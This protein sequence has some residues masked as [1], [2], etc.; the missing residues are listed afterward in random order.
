MHQVSLDYGALFDLVDMGVFV[1]EPET[2]R[3]L[4][5]NACALAMTRCTMDELRNLPLEHF[6]TSEPG[7]SVADAVTWVRKAASEGRQKLR[8]QG[9][10]LQGGIYWVD[11]VLQAVTTGTQTVILALCRNATHDRAQEQ[12]LFE[13]EARYRAIVE[14][15]DGLIYICSG[16]YQVEYMNQHFIDRTGR[17]AIGE[18]CYRALHGR[19]TICPWC[20]NDRVQAGETVRWEV[21]S[22]LDNRW[23]YIVNTPLR[24][25][26]GR[27]SKQALI[28]DVTDR[29]QAEEQRRA[30]EQKMRETQRFESLGHLA[31]GVAHDFN[32]LLLV[33]LGQMDLVLNS[34][35]ADSAL[36]ENLQEG[37]NAAQHASGLCR[38]MLTYAGKNVFKPQ[39]IDLNVHVRDVESLLRLSVSR[40]AELVLDLSSDSARMSGDPSQ[41]QQVIMNL[42]I[43]ASES[44]EG[45][46]GRIVVRT[47]SGRFTPDELACRW[48]HQPP[49]VG[50]YA[51]LEVS[52]TGI[53]I[54]EE[55]FP[56]LFDPFFSTKFTGRGLGLAAVLGIVRGHQG[57]I[58]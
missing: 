53:G 48:L 52:D 4:D 10:D 46:T 34:L 2:A 36:R 55:H 3:L 21:K 18:L 32:N 45:R 47:G 11:V 37:I 49:A 54:P 17:S 43:N 25:A 41:L 28:I 8:W 40:Q 12:S 30:L 9:R 6:L 56:H 24:H 20:V 22:P 26:D 42:V 14:A 19:D 29:R 1:V 57:S 13:A 35:P 38:Q 58:Q 51:W 5:A 39:V 16:D 50:D 33:M 7:Y 27:I 31:G 15:F 23:Y 44:L